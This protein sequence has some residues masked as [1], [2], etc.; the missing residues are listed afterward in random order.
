MPLTSVLVTY[1]HVNQYNTENHTTIPYTCTVWNW[2]WFSTL[3]ARHDYRALSFYVREW[4]PI[5]A[6]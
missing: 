1:W 5:Q 2:V 6:P 3:H 4:L